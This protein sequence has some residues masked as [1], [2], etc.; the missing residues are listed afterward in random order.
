MKSKKTAVFVSKKKANWRAKNIW[1]LRRKR[2]S[3]ANKRLN[4]T[5]LDFTERQS[6]V[7]V[8]E[9]WQQISLTFLLKI[10]SRGTKK[11][12]LRALYCFFDVH[13]ASIIIYL[14]PVDDIPT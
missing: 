8:F 14:K 9:L 11:N 1:C 5:R 13:N 2:V 4:L 12:F 6:G 3:V 10:C 7:V